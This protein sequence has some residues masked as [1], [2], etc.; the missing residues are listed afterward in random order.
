MSARLT[1]APVARFSAEWTVP[2]LP[3]TAMLPS[4]SHSANW[5]HRSPP[6]AS[7]TL[8][9]ISSAVEEGVVCAEPLA[10][11]ASA[12]TASRIKKGLD[13]AVFIQK[14]WSA[15][16]CGPSLG[17]FAHRLAGVL[18]ILSGLRKIGIRI[19][20]HRVLIAMA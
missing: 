17:G 16:G 11:N 15:L 20:Q 9:R 19:L 13:R 6:V 2:V 12:S 7:R 14:T 10:A 4:D 8:A 18:R 5:F 3:A 1:L